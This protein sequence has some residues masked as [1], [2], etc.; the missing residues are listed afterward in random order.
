[1]TFMLDGSRLVPGQSVVLTAGSTHVLSIVFAEDHGNCTLL[2]E[3]TVFLL[4]DEKWKEG[5][6]YLPLVLKSPVVWK[7][8]S[9]TR[10]ETSIS[11]T[12]GSAGSA[13][14]AGPAGSVVLEVI[15]D[16]DKKAGYDEKFMF[17]IK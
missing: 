17:V 15:R 5:K 4:N 14:S 8:V 9:S 12:A 3:K 7:S 13:G 10:H 1:M 16:C 6:D 2:P 11:F